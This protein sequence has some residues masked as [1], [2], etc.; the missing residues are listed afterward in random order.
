MRCGFLLVLD[1]VSLMNTLVIFFDIKEDSN[2]FQSRL[3][4]SE[5]VQ[6]V[7]CGMWGSTAPAAWHYLIG[8]G[9]SPA[10]ALVIL[11]LAYKAQLLKR[12]RFPNPIRP[13]VRDVA[14]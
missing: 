9:L 10:N 12:V 3:T 6:E 2:A 1:G 14:C 11:I 5:L 4:E 13:L 7:I 8:C